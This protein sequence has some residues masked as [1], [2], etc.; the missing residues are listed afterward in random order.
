MIPASSSVAVS[1]AA[2]VG[3]VVVVAEHRDHGDGEVAAG[4]GEHERLLRLSVRRQIAAEQD[5]VGL[6][7]H[8]VEGA[9]GALAQRLGAMEVGGGGQPD[10]HLVH[11]SRDTHG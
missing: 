4:V 10:R 5:Q 6:R 8:A 1:S 7:L 2:A 3:V 11:S 9:H